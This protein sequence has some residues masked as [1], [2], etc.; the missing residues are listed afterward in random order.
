MWHG[1]KCSKSCTT[2]TLN[3]LLLQSKERREHKPV[4]ADV[5]PQYRNN[6]ILKQTQAEATAQKLLR[7]C[8]APNFPTVT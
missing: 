3:T 7:W 1:F 8:E 5:A 6:P 2:A 4:S